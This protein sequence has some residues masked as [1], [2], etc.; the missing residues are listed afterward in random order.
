VRISD[1]DPLEGPPAAEHHWVTSV[2]SPTG[3]SGSLSRRPVQAKQATLA[4]RRYFIDGWTI[5]QIASE[6]DVSRFKAARLLDWARAEGIVK[7][8][9]VNTVRVDVDLSAELRSAFGLRDAVVVAALEGGSEAV[10]PDL[11]EM[12]ALVVA[13][14][15]TASDVVGVSWGRTL[16]LVVERL[17]SFHADSVV[18][19]VGGFATLESASGG[20]E[21]V[22]QL[23]AK[24]STTGYPLLAPLR[25]RDGAADA[26]RQDP[27]ISQTLGLMD[28]VTVVLAGVGSWGQPPASRMIE[29]F[30]QDEV[31]ALRERGVVA[32]LCGLLLDARGEVLDQP[33]GE[34]IGVSLGQLDAA[35]TVLAI[36]GGVEKRQALEATLRSGLVDVLV[37]DAGSAGELLVPKAKR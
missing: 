13:E 9:I 36:C 37:T 34:R 23:A 27:V 5:K 11:T 24:A 2:S 14:I 3:S 21:L 10:G 25:V 19:L 12:A 4:A 31:E 33:E 15:V 32:D 30:D 35:G 22:R 6:L 7:I 26:L 20:I 28:Q 17:P 16:D 18:Q 8:E 1:A 29:C